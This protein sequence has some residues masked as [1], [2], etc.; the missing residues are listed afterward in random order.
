MTIYWV[1]LLF[2]LSLGAAVIFTVALVSVGKSHADQ[3][4]LWLRLQRLVDHL[5][6]DAEPPQL[7]TKPLTRG[8]ARL[9][10]PE[11]VG[12]PDAQ[13]LLE[14]AGHATST[15]AAAGAPEPR[16]GALPATSTPVRDGNL[17]A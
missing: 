8:T 12:Q 5:N 17:A 7:K 13:L 14:Q 16:Q 4:A 10:Q 3:T 15:E 1:T 11:E 9:Q 2:I 6:G